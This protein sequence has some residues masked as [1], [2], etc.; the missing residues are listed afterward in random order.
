V[1]KETNPPDCGA[2]VPLNCDTSIYTGPRSQYTITPNANGSTTVVDTTTVTPAVAGVVAKGDG[3]DTL[4]NVERLQFA[5]QTVILGV[6]AAPTA[7][8]ASRLNSAAQVSWTAPTNTGTSPISDY[9]I[10]IRSG[11]SVVGT[12]DTLSAATSA[13]VVGLANGT[14][15]N[16]VVHAV[17][18]AGPGPD[19]TA[20]NTVIPAT[21]PSAPTIG[22]ATVSGTSATVTWTTPA[23]NG[24]SAITGYSVQVLDGANT[25]VG[26]LRTAPAGATSLVVAGLANGTAVHF[27]VSAVNAVGTG[28]ASAASNA[29]TPAAAVA[30]APGAPTI[31]TASALN[32]TSVTVRWT[33]PASNGGSAIT[34]YSVKVVNAAN[35][36][37]GALRTAAAG[38]TSLVVTG[39]T[40]VA[41]RFQVSAIN[42]TGTG[43]ASVLS[44]T[45]TLIVPRAPVVG[46]GVIGAVGAPVTFTARWT[47]GAANAGPAVTAY[48]VTVRRFIGPLGVGGNGVQ[49]TA[50][51]PAGAVAPTSLVITG[52]T[53][54][55]T[56]R[57]TVLAVNVVGNSAAS[58]ASASVTAR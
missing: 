9:V 10:T 57:Y 20:S 1:N 22:T 32:A 38:T 29:V 5:D 12:F 34:G 49:T 36:Q 47:A 15:Y 6:P 53:S 42:A 16:F 28:A 43:P 51:V 13:T 2:A 11:T 58:A 3:T 52:L 8:S 27:K 45:I 50:A 44:N 7:V 14:S 30:T 21:V 41:V 39:L 37:V 54:G 55:F 24:G 33:A 19:S 46:T 18:H 48:R 31:G 35:V 23:N 40:T 56:Y 4:F 25:Q 26:A 17:N